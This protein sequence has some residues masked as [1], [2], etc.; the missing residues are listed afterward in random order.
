MAGVRWDAFGLCDPIELNRIIA[1]LILVVSYNE[2]GLRSASA[3][4]RSVDRGLAHPAEEI[5]AT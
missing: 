5:G 1:P 3:S 2:V 4:T